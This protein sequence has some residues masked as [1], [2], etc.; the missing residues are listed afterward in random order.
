MHRR[1]LSVLMMLIILSAQLSMA[2]SN[3]TEN[4][5]EPWAEAGLYFGGMIVEVN[6]DLNLGFSRSGNK[7]QVD[8]EEI[9]DLD[10]KVTAFRADAFWRLSRRN[11]V[12]FTYYDLSR[13][14][15]AFL[16]INVGDY[17]IGTELSTRFD[18][19]ILKAAYAFSIFKD[20]RFDIGLGGGIHVLDIGLKLESDEFGS[21]D[22]TAITAPLPVLGLRAEFALTPKL[23]LRQSF[24]Y[25]FVAFDQFGGELKDLN[26]A[27]EYNFWKHAGVGIGYNVVVADIVA[28]DD[29]FLQG[30]ELAYSSFFLF[31]KVYF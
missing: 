28:D 9:L 22:D 20:K 3:N 1:L 7:I 19:R 31:G 16:G 21:T 29:R 27:L 15:T 25:F 12:D 17:P 30:F 26:I 2:G 18:M 10:S 23:L 6:S 13:E 14:S 8:V 24:D 4:D 11:R 5:Q